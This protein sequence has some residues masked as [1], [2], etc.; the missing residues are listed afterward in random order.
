MGDLCNPGI[1]PRSPALPADSL[2]A[3]PQG[4][5]RNTG[6]GSLSLLQRIFPTQELHRGLLHCRRILYQLS[7]YECLWDHARKPWWGGGNTAQQAT[8]R[9]CRLGR[10]TLI[11]WPM[12]NTGVKG[13][14]GGWRAEGRRRHWHPTPVPLP[15]KSHGRRSLV[16][17]SPW[18]R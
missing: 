12:G 18:G 17:C 2:P 6:V 1:E 8:L 5:P 4:K 9:S 13:D 7:Y 10:K 16:G 3:E 14:L 15:G 11:K